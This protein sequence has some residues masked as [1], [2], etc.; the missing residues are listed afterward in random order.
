M[1]PGGF[2]FVLGEEKPGGSSDSGRWAVR[3]AL[4]RAFGDR[5]AVADKTGAIATRATPMA[6]TNTQLRIARLM[7]RI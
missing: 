7:R 2:A 4:Y 1:G 5:A 6:A 3:S